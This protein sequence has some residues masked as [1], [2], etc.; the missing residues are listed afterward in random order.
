MKN[1]FVMILLLVF[2]LGAHAACAQAI[3]R[4]F[5][6]ALRQKSSRIS[7]ITCSFTQVRSSAVL[8]KPAEKKG[9]FYFK[10][11]ENI[12]L[13]Y[14]DGDHIIMTTDWFE[15]K[16]GSDVNTTKISSNPMLKSLRAILSACMVGDLS[17]LSKDFGTSVSKIK[18]GWKVVLKP[19]RG[20][21]ASR[22]SQ[23][24]LHFERSNMTLTQLK[25]EESSGDYTE[26]QFYG[27]KYN[28][29]V[30]RR[31]FNVSK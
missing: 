23:I 7:T 9:T 31:L 3:N 1:R 6:Q 22:V 21:A 24:V 4:E 19:R 8:A 16:T 14:K 13:S 5:A 17:K 10:A 27:K 11:P 2:L 25:M 12:L 29:A 30:D 28:V 20:E 15:M 18:R 26:Y